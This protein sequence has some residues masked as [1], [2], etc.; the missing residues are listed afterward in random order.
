[1]RSRL[2]Q[3]DR[4]RSILI[5]LAGMP[6]VLLGAMLVEVPLFGRKWSMV[7]TSAL[8]AV[9]LVLYA[10]ATTFEDSVRLNMMEYFCTSRP[11]SQRAR[12]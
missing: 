4:A 11:P 8:M 1:V 10:T 3:A 5:S 2:P 9:S 12:G 7:G 6:G